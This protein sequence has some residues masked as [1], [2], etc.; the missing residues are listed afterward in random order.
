MLPTKTG[1]EKY[2]E[3]EGCYIVNDSYTP[4]TCT[5]ECSYTCKGKCGC[6]ACSE[7]YGDYLGSQG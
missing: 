3:T 7:A 4:C 6:E 2:P 1:K 5:P